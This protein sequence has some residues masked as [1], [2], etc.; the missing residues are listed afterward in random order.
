[1]TRLEELLVRIER[2]ESLNNQ[3]QSSLSVVS[4]DLNDIA[5]ELVGLNSESKRNDSKITLISDRIGR[6]T[7]IH[8]AEIKLKQTEWFQHYQMELTKHQGFWTTVLGLLLAIVI[9]V[10]LV[11]ED[12]HVR[13]TMSQ[14]QARVNLILDGF[15]EKLSHHK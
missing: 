7:K 2:L 9:G 12:T 4:D 5:T 15:K 14:E 6:L 10:F 11:I 3:L 1:V 13:D 8:E